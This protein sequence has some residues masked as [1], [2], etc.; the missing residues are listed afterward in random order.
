[1]KGVY[2]RDRLVKVDK[3]HVVVEVLLQQRLWE[4]KM[5]NRMNL[6][7]L[8]NKIKRMHQ[9]RLKW[10]HRMRM[11]WLCFNRLHPLRFKPHPLYLLPLELWVNV[12][13]RCDNKIEDRRCSV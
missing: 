6:E 8:L 4:Y 7:Q 13:L 10:V 9:V 2:V 12:L 3:G 11:V 1:V 5:R